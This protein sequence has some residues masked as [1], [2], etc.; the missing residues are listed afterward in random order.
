[1]IDYTGFEGRGP[2]LLKTLSLESNPT[3][4]EKILNNELFNYFN[5]GFFKGLERKKTGQELNKKQQYILGSQTPDNFLTTE[6]SQ[7]LQSIILDEVQDI[8]SDAMSKDTKVDFSKLKKLLKRTMGSFYVA[9][10]LQ[11]V[12]LDK[13]SPDEFNYFIELLKKQL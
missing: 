6:E 9:G 3:I 2:L 5:K 12:E 4:Q 11:G 10:V 7:K 1:M 13:S 8:L